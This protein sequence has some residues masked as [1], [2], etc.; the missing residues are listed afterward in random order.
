MRASASILAELSVSH[1]SLATPRPWA[2]LGSLSFT[3]MYPLKTSFITSDAS[4]TSADDACSF[5]T[6]CVYLRSSVSAKSKF[7]L[8]KK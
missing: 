8:R 2:S 6:P 5:K 3:V 7:G 1:T 4:S